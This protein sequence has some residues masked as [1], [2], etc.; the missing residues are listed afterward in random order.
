MYAFMRRDCASIKDTFFPLQRWV[1]ISLATEF[2]YIDCVVN[3]P[4]TISYHRKLP[5]SFF[6]YVIAHSR[7][8]VYIAQAL[9][10]DHWSV[11]GKPL[12]MQLQDYFSARIKAADYRQVLR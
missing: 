7:N 2:C 6:S 3:R 9:F 10:E 11:L 1:T 12:S 4:A 5:A 8:K